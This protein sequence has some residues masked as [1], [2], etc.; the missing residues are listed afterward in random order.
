MSRPRKWTLDEIR[1]LK[2]DAITAEQAAGPLGMT[3]QAVRNA[4]WNNRDALGF[5][6]V[7]YGTGRVVIPRLAFLKFMEG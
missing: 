5:S 1:A 7:C 3:P 4:A 6:V 2:C